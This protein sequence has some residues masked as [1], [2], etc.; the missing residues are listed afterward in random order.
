MTVGLLKVR[1]LTN[2]LHVVPRLS[3]NETGDR[4]SY[5][6]ILEHVESETECYISNKMTPTYARVS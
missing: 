2:W 5:F 3:E 6:D 4:Q 1:R